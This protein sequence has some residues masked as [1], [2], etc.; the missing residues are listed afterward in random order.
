MTVIRMPER[1]WSAAHAHLFTEPGEHVAFFLAGWTYSQGQPVFMVRDVLLV[2]DTRLSVEW[3]GV[4]LSLDGIL[5]VV[6]TAVKRGDCLIEAH[7]HCGSMPRFS[8]IDRQGLKEFATYIGDSLPGRPYAATVWGD[9][10]VYGEYF[11][12]DGSA[13]VVDSIT[14]MGAQLRRV[15]SRD[16]DHVEVE[17]AFN[18]QLAWFTSEGQRQLGRL[19]VGIVGCGGTGSHVIQLLAYLGCRDFILIDDDV[20]DETSMNRLV[21]ATAADVET[22]KVILGRRLIKSVAPTARVLALKT[23]LQSRDALDALKGVDVIFGCVDN[24]GARL[25]LNEVALAYGIPYIDLAVGIGADRGVVSQAG[26]RVVMVVPGGPCLNC[27]GEIDTAEAA[28]FLSSRTDQEQQVNRGYVTGVNVSAPAVVSLNAMIAAAAVNEFANLVS[29]LRPVNVY[30][31]YDLLG[32]GRPVKSQWV[33]PTSVRRNSSCVECTV[34]GLGDASGL[35][36]YALGAE[37]GE[38]KDESDRLIAE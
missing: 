38:G 37:A 32:Q 26:G 17:P 2:P 8:S 10:T 36:R 5:D 3:E 23:R 25:I 12:P 7:N 22:P 9:S 13:G 21:T 14:V 24:D 29:G 15:I 18:R 19:R 33:V 11:M 35:D 30:T 34:A 6:N 31:E 27:L 1:I 20:A 28:Y 4:N 16:D